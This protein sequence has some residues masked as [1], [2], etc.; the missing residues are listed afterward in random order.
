MF[1]SV[2]IFAIFATASA[3]MGQ[4]GHYREECKTELDIPQESI[5]NFSKYIDSQ[6]KVLFT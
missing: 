6:P 3:H 4:M 1:K 5:D 2:L